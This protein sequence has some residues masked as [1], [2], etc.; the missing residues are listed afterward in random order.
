MIQTDSQHWF[1]F[2]PASITTSTAA[3][4]GA[5]D[6]NRRRGNVVA[7]AVEPALSDAMCNCPTEATS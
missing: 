4:P 5:W 7:E 2:G 3:G 1:A 6:A